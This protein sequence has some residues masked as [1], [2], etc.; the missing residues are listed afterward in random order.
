MSTINS[1]T[2]KHIERNGGKANKKVVR[3]QQINTARTCITSSTLH[4]L[5]MMPP[6]RHTF[7]KRLD[8]MLKN[9]VASY[10]DYCTVTVAYEI[11][12]TCW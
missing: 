5:E 8:T 1:N 3:K 9:K 6:S 10:S 11:A 12:P 2:S 7:A 4:V